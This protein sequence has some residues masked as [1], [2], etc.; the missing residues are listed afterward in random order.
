MSPAQPQEQNSGT[1][2]NIHKPIGW[3][4]NDVIRF[5]KNRVGGKVG[6]AGTLDP[7]ADGVLLVAVGKATKQIPTLM[8]LEKEYVATLQFGIETDTLDISG[9]IIKQADVPSELNEKVDNVLP[10]FRGEIEQMPPAFS[11]LH[12][13]GKRAYELAREGKEVKLES[14][15]VTIHSLDVIDIKESQMTISVCCSKGTY[16]RSLARDMAEAIGSV[17]FLRTLTRTRIGDYSIK[18]AESLTQLDH[19]L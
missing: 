14:R 12:V 3:S 5:I 15:I 17:G 7:F 4:S 2:L 11:A 6:H 19:R 9:T 1:I 13:K 16:I 10:R 18:D 8:P